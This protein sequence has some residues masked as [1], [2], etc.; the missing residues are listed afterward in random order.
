MLLQRLSRANVGFDEMEWTVTELWLKVVWVSVLR[1]E[2]GLLVCE[3]YFGK[4][5]IRF[6]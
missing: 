5:V 1:W 2:M 6:I 4:F 3:K